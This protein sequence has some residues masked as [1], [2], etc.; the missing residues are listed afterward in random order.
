MEAEW[1]VA[2]ARPLAVSLRPGFLNAEPLPNFGGG[3]VTDRRSTRSPPCAAA[4][5]AKPKGSFLCQPFY[6]LF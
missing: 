4:Q 1:A 5:N 3:I 6:F 2:A